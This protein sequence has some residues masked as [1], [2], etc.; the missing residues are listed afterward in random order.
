MPKVLVTDGLEAAAVESMRRAG[1][2]V[3]E[4]KAD[5]ARL[6][7]VHALI[8]R[9]ATKVT[10]ELLAAAP[11]LKCVVRAGVGVDN[12]DLPAAKARGV[13]VMNTPGGSTNAV[14]ELAMGMIFSLAREIPRADA[15]MKAGKWEKKA[16]E[17]GEVSGKTLGVIGLGRIGLALAKKA[18]GVGM[19]V[20]GCDPVTPAEA[21][22]AAGVEKVAEADVLR[23]ADY[24]SFH[25]PSLPETKGMVNA[26]YLARMKK[27]VYLLNCARGNVI[28]EADLLAALD[29]GQVAGAALDVFAAEPPKD[30]ATKRLAAHPKVVATP[31][32]GAATREGQ[33][34]LGQEAAE[35][36]VACLVRGEK[37]NLV[38]G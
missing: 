16:F 21:A 30:D 31:H 26:A 24:V 3:A 4:E 7:G 11:D 9:S 6:A 34:A 37:R 25:V 28:S 18:V 8:I 32:V 5:P 27:G 35:V 17:G 1:L 14:A 33:A 19:T 38:G 36:A 13:A 22:R 15:S 23:R 20:V 12:V 10:K 29:S 2:E